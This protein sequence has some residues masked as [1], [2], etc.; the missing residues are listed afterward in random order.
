MKS[1]VEEFKKFMMRGNVIDLAVGV[2]IGTAFNNVV[3]SL[4]NNI[5]T[6]PL[7]LLI[8]R[9]D[10]KSWALNLGGD[11]NIQYGLF[12]Q[13]IISFLIT[14]FALF[15]LVRFVSRV[16]RLAKN[17][18]PAEPPPDSLKS[19]ELVVLEEIRDRLAPSIPPAH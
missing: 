7:G 15:L 6:P 1:F 3:T 2:V 11:V 9:V 16:E 19:P 8:G 14:A 10:F 5:V 17:D 18:P 12:I 4:V 13:A